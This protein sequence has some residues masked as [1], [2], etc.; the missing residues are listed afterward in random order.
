MPKPTDKTIARDVGDA[1]EALATAADNT[2]GAST[3]VHKAVHRC[4]AQA[5]DAAYLAADL[6]QDAVDKEEQIDV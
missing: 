6:A 4:I 2:A 3:P 1:A 5:A